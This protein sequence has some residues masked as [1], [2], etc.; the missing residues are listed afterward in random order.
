[1]V[2]KVKLIHENQQEDRPEIGTPEFDVWIKEYAKKTADFYFD[3]NRVTPE[4]D[5]ETSFSS[6]SWDFLYQSDE[7]LD[8]ENKS[9][10]KADEE[11]RRKNLKIVKNKKNDL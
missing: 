6:G 5:E 8:A 10:E 9:I 3:E 11:R 2:K 1:M 4:L 7:E